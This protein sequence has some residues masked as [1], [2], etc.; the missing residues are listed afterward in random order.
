VSVL[1]EEK[2]KKKRK[3]S[4]FFFLEI[5]VDLSSRTRKLQTLK[6]K[7]K[8]AHHPKLRGPV[9]LLPAPR[10]HQQV[11]RRRPH[12]VG[13]ARAQ[14]LAQL[15]R[16]VPR[17]GR[18]PRGAELD[19]PHPSLTSLLSV[20]APAAAAQE[21][22]Q[23]QSVRQG[24]EGERAEGARGGDRV[25]EEHG[26]EVGGR[27]GDRQGP[28]RGDGGSEPARSHTPGPGDEGPGSRKRRKERGKERSESELIVVAFFVLFRTFFDL[29][30]LK[31]KLSLSPYQ[32]ALLSRTPAASGDSPGGHNA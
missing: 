8:K 18:Q 24:S 2:K 26:G 32:S 17:G 13:V 30:N 4:E 16:G 25:G 19:L 22:A 29:E 10:R 20:A 23:G 14:G 31:K 1:K 5:F 9:K 7:K 15:R 27:R 21:V 28:S 3:K 11:R 6:K 12:A